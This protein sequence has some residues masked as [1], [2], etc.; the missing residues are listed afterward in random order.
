[1]N[2]ELK[3]VT[4]VGRAIIEDGKLTQHIN[5]TAGP[6]GTPAD[7]ENYWFKAR[8]VVYEYTGDSIAAAEAGIEAFATQWVADNYPSI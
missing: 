1:M 2:F 3:N 7:D 6:V 5:I 4:T 8:T